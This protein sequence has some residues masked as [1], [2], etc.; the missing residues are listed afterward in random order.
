MPPTRTGGGSPGC[1]EGSGITSGWYCIAT[2][3]KERLPGPLAEGLVLGGSPWSLALRAGKRE[4]EN[5]PSVASNL[6][7]LLWTGRERRS[8]R[9]GVKH[10]QSCW[11][12]GSL[13]AVFG[14]RLAS[15]GPETEEKLPRGTGGCAGGTGLPDA[16][17]RP[18]AAVSALPT[19]SFPG[20][21]GFRH[22]DASNVFSSCELLGAR[23]SGRELAALGPDVL[24]GDGQ[25]GGSHARGVLR[26][27][28]RGVSA[29]CQP[30]PAQALHGPRKPR[31]RERRSLP[32]Y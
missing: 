25:V 32:G 30:H 26:G 20:V 9:R 21:F 24:I 4:L 6:P 19:A 29:P 28:E 17:P 8:R 10:L 22:G 16:G 18:P 27:E 12:T 14:P 13:V 7:E 2:G 3:A 11:H 1:Q 23:A 5:L 15:G 31:T